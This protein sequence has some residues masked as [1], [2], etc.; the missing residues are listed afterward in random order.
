MPITAGSFVAHYRLI[1]PIGEGGMG[2]VWRAHDTRLDRDVAVKFILPEFVSNP[3]RRRRFEREARVLAALN[4]PNVAAIY[5]LEIH[6]DEGTESPVLILELVAGE[7]LSAPIARGA[8]PAADTLGIAGQILDGL[9]AAHEAGI[10]HRDLKPANV[11]VTPGGQ[12]KILDFGIATASPPAHADRA[13][14]RTRTSATLAGSILGT[15]GYMSPEQARGQ[16]VDARSD[17][18]SFGCILFEMLVAHPAFDGPTV[19]DTIAAVLT[20]DPDFTTLPAGTPDAVRD[21]ITRCLAKDAAQRPSGAQEARTI[22]RA[23]RDP[24]GVASDAAVS[25]R[26]TQET[27]GDA[28]DGLPA[29]SPD[30]SEIVYAAGVFGVR[31]ITRLR[32]GS[33]DAATLTRGEADDLMPAWSPDGATILFVRG[34][35][36]GVRLEPG[37]VY[38]EYADTDVWAL[39]LASGRETRWVD[40]ACNPTFSPDGGTVAVDAAWAGPRRIWQLDTRGR[41]PVQISTDVSEAVSHTRPRYSPDGR[42]LVFQAQ[43]RTRFNVGIVFVASRKTDRLTNDVWSDL[44]PVWS[45]S[46]RFVY[47]SSF[48]SGGLNIWRLPVAMDGTARGAPQQVTNGA[49]QDVE[50]A[51]AP[52]GRRLAF[53][54][55]RQNAS[56]Y[57]L[58]V[59]VA[60][61]RPTGT[62]R[63]LMTTSR[64]DSRGAWSPDGGMIAFNSARSG[65]MSLW[66]HHIKTGQ[67][68]AMTSG[69]GGDYQPTWSP[70][71]RK[72][73]FFSSRNGSPGIWTVDVASGTLTRLST[74]RAIEINP[75]YSRDGGHIAY[76]SDRDGRLEVWLM[77]ADGSEPRQLTRCGVG[78]HFLRFANDGGHVIFRCPGMGA[79]L[80][81]AMDGGEP[82]SMGTI[83]GG[84]HMSLSPDARKILDVVAHKTLWVSTIGGD[85]PEAVFEF[86]DPG[87]RIDYPVWSPDGSQVVFDR[88][89]PQG[90]DIWSLDGVE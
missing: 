85:A 23:A 3:E 32:L 59:A 61:G 89:R 62:P 73:V 58:P 43:E 11:R 63:R 80:R 41:N 27:F 5:G 67:T 52:G 33:G 4:H 77:R 50:I 55:Q 82:Q 53:A 2:S 47:F 19:S 35:K 46:G 44:N 30:G 20:K 70:D 8:V 51:V 88:F 42:A 28:I 64:D 1:E 14:E 65:N 17:I 29:F 37:D 76:Q 68:R 75:F 86:E 39:D 79:T 18:W 66:L 7:S 56:L 49:G 12:V 21:L 74:E 45:P 13:N 34:R 72:L 71:G 38:G 84:A 6:R 22:L 48:R 31:K 54:I 90:G 57:T 16:A 9:A 10:V 83:A 25:P 60:T 26:L 24:G 69:P 40:G 87:V 15:P 81:V 36:P 78:G